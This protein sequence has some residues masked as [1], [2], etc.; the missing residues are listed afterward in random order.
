MLLDELMKLRDKVRV[1]AEIEI[2]GDPVLEH[3]DAEIFEPPD[4]GL[5]KRFVAEV[6]E[7]RPTPQR[8]SSLE[9]VGAARAGSPAASASRPAAATSSKR[10]RSSWPPSAGAH[11]R[12]PCHQ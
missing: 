9:S 4:L 5:R 7:R 2:R 6:G 12:R 3:G 11:T 1:A 10:S 8:E